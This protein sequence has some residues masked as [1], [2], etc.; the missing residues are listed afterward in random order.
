MK[1]FFL[2]PL[3]Q[4]RK[5]SDLD[6]LVR[7]TDPDPHQ[8]VTDPQHWYNHTSLFWSTK[9]ALQK[10]LSGP[11][12]SK[13]YQPFRAESKIHNLDQSV[14]NI[15]NG[16]FCNVFLFVQCTLFFPRDST[17]TCG[18]CTA[19]QSVN[20]FYCMFLINFLNISIW[21]IACFCPLFHKIDPWFDDG[22]RCMSTT[23]GP[24][25][26]AP[27]SIPAG[28]GARSSASTWVIYAV[29]IFSAKLQIWASLPTLIMLIK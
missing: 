24:S 29:F 17:V 12:L 11:C 10:I 9:S 28:T 13:K 20:L 25:R 23:S 6:P 5:E 27:N 8:N 1:K 19:N 4:W 22:F 7:G 16:Y 14:D 18:H 26:T 2:H 15:R 3:S 21:N